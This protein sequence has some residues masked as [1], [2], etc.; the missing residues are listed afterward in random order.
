MINIFDNIKH[1]F[2]TVIA[3]V[4][5]AVSTVLPIHHKP[6][7]PS[8]NQ[9]RQVVQEVEKE[10][11]PSSELSKPVKVNKNEP[12]QEKTT[13]ILSPSTS[14]PTSTPT[15][16]STLI[17]QESKTQPVYQAIPTPSQTFQFTIPFSGATV[18]CKISGLN[19]LTSAA[20]AYQTSHN[21]MPIAF[22][23]IKQQAKECADNCSVTAQP[24]QSCLD[25]CFDQSCI[26][27]CKAKTPNEDCLTPCYKAFGTENYNCFDDCK[28]KA[29]AECITNCNLHAIDEMTDYKNKDLDLSSRVNSLVNQY[30]N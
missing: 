29:A 27:D 9:N 30:C 23:N 24:A 18:I 15:P 12:T 20:T 25:G 4:V 2:V 7:Q 16:I 28:Y 21:Y 13:K 22:Q 5:T 26:A 1:L 14:T 6:Q 19:D 10:A 11:T 8:S 3:V 17:P